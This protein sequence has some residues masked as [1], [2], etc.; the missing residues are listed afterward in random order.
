MLAF[1]GCW[2]TAGA[3]PP[4]RRPRTLSAGCSRSTPNGNTIWPVSGTAPD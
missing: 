2:S 4:S 1:G 3:S